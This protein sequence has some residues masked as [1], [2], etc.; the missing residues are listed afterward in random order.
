MIQA[1]LSAFPA[2]FRHDGRFPIH[3]GQPVSS[4]P[5]EERP[6]TPIHDARAQQ[7]DHDETA[8][9]A[10]HGFVLLDHISAVTDWSA[11][12]ST[13]YLAELE[14]LIRTRLLPGKKLFI[15]P[16]A[17]VVRRGPDT[18]NAYATGVHQD[19]GIGPDDYQQLVGA[20][21]SEA[22]AIGWRQGFDRDDVESY[23]LIDFWR[24][25][26]MREPLRHM[27]LALC[28]PSSVDLDD[29][30]PTEIHGIAA[31]GPVHQMAVRRN[32]AQRWV[33]YPAMTGDE[34]LAFKLYDCRKGDNGEL[35]SCFH[36]AFAD[37][38]APEDAEPRSSCECRVGVFVLKG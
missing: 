37:P 7:R 23:V 14:A 25:I 18:G 21:A 10:D 11:D 33:Y 3:L 15:P 4:R 19:C 26:H 5:P 28:E 35:R 1:Q 31:N 29:I 30:V 9:F 24:P 17:T 8:F 27:P 2:G 38:T 13:G 32:P 20:F 12:P 36:T 6:F 16:F 34:V 22:A